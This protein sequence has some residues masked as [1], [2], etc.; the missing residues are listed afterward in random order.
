MLTSTEAVMEDQIEEFLSDN[1]GV[2]SVAEL[3]ELLEADEGLVRRWARENG[4]RRVGA[5]F[6]FAKDSAFSCADDL[7]GDD[8]D[9]DDLEDE[10]SE[11]DDDD[12]LDEDGEDEVANA[13]QR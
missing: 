3:A 9:D 5:T 4:V 7:I 6:V 10:D 11:D 8:D 13:R 12:D 2:M 1:G